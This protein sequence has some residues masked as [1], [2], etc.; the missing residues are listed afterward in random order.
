MS[1]RS[2]KPANTQPTLT[3]TSQSSR[4]HNDTLTTLST[5]IDIKQVNVSWGQ[6]DLLADAN[7]RLKAGVHYALVGRNGEGKST[8]LKAIADKVIPGIPDN[9]RILLIDQVAEN[10]SF[11]LHGEE[12]V[13]STELSV[14]QT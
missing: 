3:A 9:L 2:V 8:L 4:F 5:E 1:R 7:L 11:L 14:A 12:G 13:Q 10:Q 6:Y